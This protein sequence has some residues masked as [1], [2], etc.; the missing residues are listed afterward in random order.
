MLSLYLGLNLFLIR[1]G[2]SIFTLCSP[3]TGHFHPVQ[4]VTH[5]FNHAD[6]QHLIFN[7]MSFLLHWSLQGT[8]FGATEIFN[9]I[10]LS[11][12]LLV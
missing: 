2:R 1:S 4:I 5:M 8:N 10:F 3:S 9:F 6:E 11:E 12:L 7:M